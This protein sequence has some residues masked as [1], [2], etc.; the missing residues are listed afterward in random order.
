MMN[1]LALALLLQDPAACEC[2]ASIKVA[3]GKV[4]LTY[5]ETEITMLPLVMGKCLLLGKE[6][7]LTK[8]GSLKCPCGKTVKHKALTE[9][10][11][12]TGATSCSYCQATWTVTDTEVS[13]EGGKFA[14]AKF[15][16]SYPIRDHKARVGSE[17]N[18]LTA[19]E[20][21]CLCT[22]GKVPLG[23]GQPVEA[24]KKA[25]KKLGRV[26]CACG[27]AAT[28]FENVAKIEFD[29]KDVAQI[30]VVE[31]KLKVCGQEIDVTA[32]SEFKCPCGATVSVKLGS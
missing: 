6:T 27:A 1:T 28:V 26:E 21:N 29:K 25:G 23:D 3:D 14:G 16:K 7:D 30:P 20:F 13:W 8:A 4:V 22:M 10:K 32:E 19:T 31:G 11:H 17:V 2:G 5:Q 18:L 24:A 15:D 9:L 12:W